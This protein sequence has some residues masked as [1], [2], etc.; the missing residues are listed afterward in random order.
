M[1]KIA[2]AIFCAVALSFSFI[3]VAEAATPTVGNRKC[4]IIGTSKNDILRGS[5]KLDVICGLGGNDT[6]YGLGGDD[7]IDGGAGN[8]T[9]YGDTGND[10]ITAGDGNDVVNG[11][12]GNDTISGS[13]GTDVISGESGNDTI[14]AGDGNDTV[15][16]GTGNDTISGN[17]GSDKLT[18]EAG[19]D[20]I[21]GDVGSDLIAGGT[22]SDDLAGGDG[23]DRITGGS[24]VDEI[25]GGLGVDL[26][27]LSDKD[28][29]EECVQVQ[30]DV[31][32]SKL[33]TGH[34]YAGNGDPLVGEQIVLRPYP[35]D[36]SNLRPTAISIIGNEG[37][38]VLYGATGKYT[39]ESTYFESDPFT[40]STDV[41]WTLRL[42]EMHS[43]TLHAELPAGG[44][45]YGG[46][47][48]RTPGIKFNLSP[49]FVITKSMLTQGTCTDLGD[50][51]YL[52]TWAGESPSYE[53]CASNSSYIWASCATGI[54]SDGTKTVV[55]PALPELVE[56]SGKVSYSDGSPVANKRV[57]VLRYDQIHGQFETS[58]DDAGNY[59]LQVP[60]GNIHLSIDSPTRAWVIDEIN[61]PNDK[62][63][64]LQ[65]PVEATSKFKFVDKNQTPLE[66]IG[67]LT[68]PSQ[69]ADYEVSPGVIAHSNAAL[70]ISI[71]NSNGELEFVY[72]PTGP[73]VTAM[74]G[75]TLPS[76]VTIQV[77]ITLQETP[78]TIVFEASTLYTVKLKVLE[79]TGG[80]ALC[81]VLLTNKDSKAAG[82]W[83]E[84]FINGSEL[85]PLYATKGNYLVNLD[86]RDQ[87]SQE[88][89]SMKVDLVVTGNQTLTWVL[90]KRKTVKLH[91]QYDDK[92]PVSN[93]YVS[94][95]FPSAYFLLAKNV[96]TQLKNLVYGQTP[97][98]EKGDLEIL[99]F[100]PVSTKPI[101]V[102]IV[103]EGNLKQVPVVLTGEDQTI[104]IN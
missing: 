56:L 55:V 41:N 71:S 74:V 13:T 1:R 6:I 77:P 72:L 3:S 36:E 47:C 69:E 61:V 79:A 75:R 53:V 17:S 70:A 80:Y 10:A 90:P 87:E 19:N 43:M 73:Q 8:D 28:S 76:R 14:T 45:L 24:D 9:I 83:Q 78:Q 26:C 30:G 63:F 58:T 100:G 16:G 27:S 64:N 38:F 102:S 25:D 39:L 20:A 103:S 48:T 22:G 7:I 97:S 96:K 2:L 21:N 65:I 91:F 85:L 95:S 62:V 81:G 84:G 51:N 46:G 44:V 68:V 93:V 60:V 37:E 98:D 12:T 40:L 5:K 92:T 101:L 86:C 52:H 34:L 88:W 29:F 4:T 49:E 54:M 33:V 31:W 57:L 89:F 11:G 50:N 82:V 66:G 104:T 67:L 59:S 99:L 15:S 94:N 42:P 18:G 35:M 23:T 32:T